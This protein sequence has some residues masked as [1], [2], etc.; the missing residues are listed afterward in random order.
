MKLNIE[1][2][3]LRH[4][5]EYSTSLYNYNP[6]ECNNPNGEIH[7]NENYKRKMIRTK[8]HNGNYANKWIATIDND[9]SQTTRWYHNKTSIGDTPQDAI[10]NLLNKKF[11]KE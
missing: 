2:L 3:V 11:I 7:Y 5:P 6:T 1:G 4:I 10:D 8:K 9:T